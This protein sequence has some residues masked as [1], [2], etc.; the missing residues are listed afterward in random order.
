MD[1]PNNGP[2]PLEAI[3]NIAQADGAATAPPPPAAPPP[4]QQ[5]P[6]QQPPAQPLRNAPKFNDYSQGLA[7]TLTAE[8]RKL[9]KAREDI[10]D[11]MLTAGR[12]R[13]AEFEAA[14]LAYDERVKIATQAFVD[15]NAM[16][17]AKANDAI[18]AQESIA[19]ALNV[20]LP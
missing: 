19:R 11:Q 16:L 3:R 12:V 15:A 5:P 10:T 9:D 6:A 18:L 14:K 20:L 4:A 1:E 13:D 8:K 7:G 2:D 17:E